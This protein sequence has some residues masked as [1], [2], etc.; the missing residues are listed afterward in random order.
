VE[1][2]VS[3]LG[4][5][6]LLLR[7]EL[8]LQ[9]GG[10]AESLETG[11]DYEFCQRA[12]AAGAVILN[13]PKLRV[14]HHDFPQT[15]RQFVRREAWHGGGDLQS[16]RSLLQSKVAM[17][18]MVFLLAHALI[19]TG[20]LQP[21][22]ALLGALLLGALLAASTWKKYRHAPWRSRLI[23]GGLFYAYYLGRSLSFLRLLP[24]RPARAPRLAG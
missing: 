9:L 14:V 12:R 2:D 15:L 17:G 13:D 22:A 7:R 24:R 10:F 19:F 16:L 18:A 3:H 21:V 4:T 8:F 11:E 5:G 20:L 6:H 23:N 1:Q